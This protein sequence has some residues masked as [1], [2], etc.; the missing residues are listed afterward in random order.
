MSSWIIFSEKALLPL[1]PQALSVSGNL[2][3]HNQFIP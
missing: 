3:Y 2:R 1:I